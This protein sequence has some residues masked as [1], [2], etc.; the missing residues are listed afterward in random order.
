MLSR[1]NVLK[2]M[3]TAALTPAAMFQEI[4]ASNLALKDLTNGKI[5]H[6]ACRWCYSTIPLDELC[7]KGKKIGLE[8]LDLIAP[9]EFETMKKNKL[10]A[11][12]VSPDGLKDYLQVGWNHLEHHDTLVNFYTNLIETTAKAGFNNVIVFSGNR[13]GLNDE[14]GLKNCAEG[15][16]KILSIAEKNK[17]N[18]V[19]ELLNSKVNHPDYQCDHTKWGVE[20][21]KTLS[22]DRFSLLYDIYHMQIMEGDIIRTIK[23]NIKYLSHF[24]TGGVP[25]RNEIDSS[26]E[27]FYPSIM[28]AIAAT[29]FKG[30]VAQ[31]F[32]PTNPD[33]LASL[34]SAVKICDI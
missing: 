26:Q 11:S 21:C 14:D 27:L 1:R 34:K 9:A 3:A 29:G 30:F 24:H 32:I 17:I 19:M 15:L 8:A 18:L 13:K 23:D 10:H 25:G 6:S 5:R 2:T 16:K 33:K 22:T 31:E 4:E 12:M 20:L 28:K 7:K